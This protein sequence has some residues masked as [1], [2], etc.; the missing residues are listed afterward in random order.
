[1]QPKILLVD[2][3]P[4]ITAALQRVLCHEFYELLT[5]HSADEA[6]A[7][8]SR[9]SI[10]VIVSD[11]RMPGMSGSEFLALVRHNYPDT[12]RIILTGH[13]SLEVA[14]R[15]INKGEV[16][17]FLMKPCNRHDLTDA[18]EYGLE[19]KERRGGTP[20]SEA[21]TKRTSVLLREL[22]TQT[23][24]I[25]QVNRDPSGAIILEEEVDVD[26][27]VQTLKLV[28]AKRIAS[29][30]KGESKP[31]PLRAQSKVHS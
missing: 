6:L 9:T 13:A 18:I 8:L 25:T 21:R 19:Q 5:A 12:V 3:D 27:L 28:A 15:A 24:G 10:D 7:I 1:V 2:D 14:M 17:R 23:P 4:R 16:S 26:T 31:I 29:G 30:M 11:E 20:G 22:E